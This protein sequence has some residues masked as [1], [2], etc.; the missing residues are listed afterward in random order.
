[1]VSEIEEKEVLEFEEM[2]HTHT[3]IH[4]DTHPDTHRLTHRH[5][6]AHTHKDT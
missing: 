2:R 3:E 4:T 6:D 1:M 5:T